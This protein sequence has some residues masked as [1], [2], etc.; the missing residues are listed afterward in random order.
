MGFSGKQN[1]ALAQ[2]GQICHPRASQVVQWVTNPSANAGDTRDVDSIPGL[3]RSPGERNGNPFQYP[4]IGDPMDPGRLL[5][6]G[7]QRVRH[8]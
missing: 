4:C 2:G 6:V 8:D 1:M 5:S 7:S 3:G